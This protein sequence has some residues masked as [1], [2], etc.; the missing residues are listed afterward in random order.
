MVLHDIN[1]PGSNDARSKNTPNRFRS[2][3]FTE[4]GLFCDPDDEFV[5]TGLRD[6]RRIRRQRNA[7]DYTGAA[8][9]RGSIIL[10]RSPDRSF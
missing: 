5:S 6:E 10:I 3:V 7:W 2:G 1:D 4:A 9:V 8:N